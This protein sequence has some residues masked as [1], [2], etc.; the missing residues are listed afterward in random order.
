MYIANVHCKNANSIEMRGSIR[1]TIA[2]FLHNKT[3]ISRKIV[4]FFYQT[5]K[6]IEMSIILNEKI[7][8]WKSLL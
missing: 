7:I 4:F 5:D 8:S 1:K 6:F 3:L 2:R